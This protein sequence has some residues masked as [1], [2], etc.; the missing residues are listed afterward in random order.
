MRQK[1]EKTMYANEVCLFGDSIARGVI[2]DACGSYKPIRESFA[3]LAASELGF[4]LI[5]KA[6]FGCTIAKGR[7][8]IERFLGR[9]AAKTPADLMPENASPNVAIH[10]R[11]DNSHAADSSR[12][13]LAFLEFGGND[14]DFRWD[15]IS[16]DPHREHLPATTPERFFHMYGEVLQMLKQNGFKP[17]LMTLPPLDAERYFAWFT[18]A[19]LDQAAILSWL[20]DV[21]FIYRWHESYSSAIWEIGEAHNV[22]VVN[23]RKAFLEQRNYSRFLC[24]DGIHPNTEGHRLITSEIIKFA[25]EHMSV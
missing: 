14:C 23:I 25:Q 10:I 5:N 13:R 12:P 11:T 2:L 3:F 21:Q 22:P 19:G 6:R 15:E 8:I 18:R 4:S 24:K 17:V 9:G 7:E 16:A 1:L 20:G